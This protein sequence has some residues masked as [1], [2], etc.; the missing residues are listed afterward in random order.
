[1]DIYQVTWKLTSRQNQIN[2]PKVET[3]TSL[4]KQADFD[5]KITPKLQAKR[6]KYNPTTG[7]ITWEPVVVPSYSGISQ[8]AVEITFQLEKSLRQNTSS[9]S[10]QPLYSEVIYSG[11]DD[12]T[13]QRYRKEV[14]PKNP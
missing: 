7:R 9:R 5:T 1:M 14:S 11:V 4:S 8:P 6:I 10:K 13:S 3:V 12:F 2:L